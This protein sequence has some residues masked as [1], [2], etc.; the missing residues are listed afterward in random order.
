MM[1]AM[2]AA[3]ASMSPETVP[4]ATSGLNVTQRVGGS[5]GAAVLA[6]IL[7][8]Q[9]SDAVPGGESAAQV[10]GAAGG[11]GQYAGPIGDAFG[12][13]FAWSFWLTLAAIPT[14]LILTRRERIDRRARAERETVSQSVG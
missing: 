1:P 8:A 12:T 2:A 4:R 11:L 3:Y 7:N 13:T 6:V 9:I 14:A 10:A 5:I